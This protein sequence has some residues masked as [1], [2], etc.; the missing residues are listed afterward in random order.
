[1]TSLSAIKFL[2]AFLL[3]SAFLTSSPAILL[4]EEETGL[5]E[6]IHH[7]QGNQVNQIILANQLVDLDESLTDEDY[8]NPI[9][10]RLG[11]DSVAGSILE[12]PF[13]YNLTDENQKILETGDLSQSTD[14]ELISFENENEEMYW[15]INLKHGDTLTISDLPDQY[16]YEI[17]ELETEGYTLRQQD[18]LTGN[19]S[20]PTTLDLTL[21]TVKDSA[22]ELP[23]VGGTGTLL[24]YGT[25]MLLLLNG[26]ALVVL[27]EAGKMS[28]GKRRI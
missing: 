21:L 13:P 1:M 26:G 27:N 7:N 17:E 9:Q 28:S 10:I 24:I 4:A 5:E 22:I 20:S 11:L 19:V 3:A 18:D 16:R 14:N 6:E 2:P 25:G 15:K 23:D 12:G 8:Q